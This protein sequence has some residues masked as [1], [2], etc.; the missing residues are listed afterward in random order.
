MTVGQVLLIYVLGTA[1][2]LSLFALC[3]PVT[4]GM[5]ESS[6]RQPNSAH[7]KKVTRPLGPAVPFIRFQDPFG[8]DADS[9]WGRFTV[10]FAVDVFYSSFQF[11]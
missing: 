9:G 8:G 7:A 1:P 5:P 6:Y 10:I 3:K 4:K 11:R 2:D